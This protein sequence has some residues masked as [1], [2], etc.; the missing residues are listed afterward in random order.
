MYFYFCQCMSLQ[1]CPGEI[2]ILDSLLTKETGILILVSTFTNSSMH[3]AF[4]LT[5]IAEM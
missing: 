3:S 4:S 5:F 2:L 1:V